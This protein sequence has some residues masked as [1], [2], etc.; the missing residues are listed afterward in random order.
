MLTMN[1][2]LV[3]DNFTARE[4][5]HAQGLDD[6]DVEQLRDYLYDDI[7]S[8]LEYSA[9]INKQEKEYYESSCDEYSSA[10]SDA[11]NLIDDILSKQRIINARDKLESVIT[12]L[13]NA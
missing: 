4:A 7:I 8:D 2:M 10:I 3:Y 9:K 12:I 6:W 13:I 11:I 5:L 1:K